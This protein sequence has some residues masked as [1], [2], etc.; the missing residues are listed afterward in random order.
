M[1]GGSYLQMAA[2]L[3]QST[4]MLKSLGLGELQ[5]FSKA[6]LG[7]RPFA[8]EDKRA[9]LATQTLTGKD[10]QTISY[11]LDGILLGDFVNA[12]HLEIQLPALADT[13]GALSSWV[14]AVGFA[15]IET[16]RITIGGEQ[17][18]LLGGDYMELYDELHKKPGQ[19]LQ[20]AALKMD[21]VTIPEMADLSKVRRTLYVPIPFF[22]TRSP[23]CILPVGKH[24]DKMVGRNVRVEIEL[25]LR[26]INEISY[27]LPRGYSVTQSDNSIDWHDGG[28]AFSSAQVPDGSSTRA[29]D[30]SDIKV[31]LYVKQV[32]LDDTEARAMWLGGGPRGTYRAMCT[33]VQGLNKADTAYQSFDAA[34]TIDRKRV[35]LRC[36]TKNILLA[37]RDTETL[38]RKIHN[39]ETLDPY[40]LVDSSNAPL[41]VGVS[42]LYG[43]KASHKVDSTSAKY[44]T[45]WNAQKTGTQDLGTFKKSDHGDLI[46]ADDTTPLRSNGDVMEFRSNGHLSGYLPL[47]RFDYRAVKDKKEVEAI[48]E[49]SLKLM[50]NARI[51]VNNDN[52]LHASYLRT[53]QALAFNN[54][55][56]KGIY[57]YSFAVDSSSPYPTGTINMSRINNQDLRVKA[58]GETSESLELVMFS[59]CVN[60]FE[61][62][63]A[64]TSGRMMYC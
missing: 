15:M 55:P 42:A 37:V 52:A 20:E 25:T 33:T 58:G 13:A 40:N 64:N 47:N 60:I 27:G 18:E 32:F 41:T 11:N 56:R 34:N 31:Q 7:V 43:Q 57:V 53:V 49:L 1:S 10:K 5:V 16:A 35:G 17:V 21:R 44:V 62:D 30:Y 39:K 14:W 8:L 29:L 24:F 28:T 26:A 6:Y 38:M 51:E 45:D 61:I 22:F 12:C 36:P 54:T 9:T 2:N 63:P 59:E 50:G 48:M 46:T 19:H 23:H 4:L 3:A